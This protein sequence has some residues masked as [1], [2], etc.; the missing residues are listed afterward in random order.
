[1]HDTIGGEQSRG[2]EWVE[3]TTFVS[4]SV[5]SSDFG[6]STHPNDSFRLRQEM[7]NKALSLAQKGVLITLS[8]HQCS[9]L[10]DEPCSFNQGVLGTL[11]HVQ[12]EELLN[13]HSALHQ[14]WKDQMKKIGVYLQSL[15]KQKITVY[16][17]PYHEGNAPGFWWAGQASYYKRLWIMLHDYYI[18]ELKLTNLKW[19]WSV[20]FHPLYWNDLQAYY[21]GDNFVDVI[22][23]DAYPP[24]K[25][26]P[27][28]YQQIYLD[29]KKVSSSKPLALTE[30]SRL[31]HK[32]ELKNSSWFY[33][34]PWGV[35]LLKRDNSI[36]EIQSWYRQD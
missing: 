27:P 17:R 26:L 5:W 18:N 19:V 24:K 21:P 8:Y 9:V 33:V 30:V 31:P 4:P 32:D 12:W 20:S 35:N 34:V 11:S 1:M 2:L 3:R 6:F 7:I 13:P 22:G 23:A 16:F 14:R 36:D 10:M 28:P 29:L 25:D 15:D